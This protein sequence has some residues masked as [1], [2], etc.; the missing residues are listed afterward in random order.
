MIIKDLVGGFKAVPITACTLNG[1]HLSQL[2]IEVEPYKG[3]WAL[4]APNGYAVDNENHRPYQYRDVE[5]AEE[6]AR[7]LLSFGEY[8]TCGGVVNCRKVSNQR[9][10]SVTVK[11][12]WDKK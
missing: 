2:H 3:N 6:S 1:I 8:S 11:T 5:E 7:Q 9:A 4:V 10:P 12:P